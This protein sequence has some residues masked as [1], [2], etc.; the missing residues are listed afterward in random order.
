MD[1]KRLEEL[2]KQGIA[3]SEQLR[4]AKP[5]SKGKKSSKFYFLKSLE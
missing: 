5:K 2:S 1:Q 3:D 4:T